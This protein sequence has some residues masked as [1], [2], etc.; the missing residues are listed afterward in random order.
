MY[1]CIKNALRKPLNSSLRVGLI[2]T[3]ILQ[4]SVSTQAQGLDRH[5]INDDGQPK[6]LS[7][8]R[9]LG[10]SDYEEFRAGRSKIQILSSV[11]W[12]GNFEM[13]CRDNSNKI[14]GI[15]FEFFS[16]RPTEAWGEPAWAIFVNEKFVKFVRWPKRKM[17]D[18]R[19]PYKG[20]ITV[21]SVPEPIQLGNFERLTLAADNK[22]VTIADL[23]QDVK[24]R[25]ETP[26]EI[27]PGLTIMFLLMQASGVK[28][29][30][31]ERDLKINA[32]LR[33]Q[34]NASRLDI[35]MTEVQVTATFHA[36]PICSGKW[37]AGSFA[38]YGSLKSVDLIAPLH[39]SNVLVLYEDGK[40]SGIYSGETIPGGKDSLRKLRETFVDFPPCSP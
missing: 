30:P 32:S 37:H 5:P 18:V 19:V 12:R 20:G 27:D 2:L 13:G 6:V 35:G 14:Y 34:F 38:V 3:C 7:I 24:A 8:H 25:G 28:L 39:Y 33:D 22:P 26:R 23:V 11:Q 29:E 21:V 1:V 31:S 16:N 15:S 40:V 10:R 36:K 17:K 9:L 4:I